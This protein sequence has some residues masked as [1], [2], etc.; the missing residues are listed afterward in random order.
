MN[1]ENIIFESYDQ[2]YIENVID[3]LQDVSKYRPLN[4]SDPSFS[5]SFLK[6]NNVYALVALYEKKVIGFGSIFIFERVRG[7]KSAILEDIVVKNSFR[8]RKV[9]TQIINILIKYAATNKCFKISLESSEF[10]KNFYRKLGF[11]DKGNIMNKFL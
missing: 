4:S 2:K 11:V 9:G 6:Q 5:N 7:G 1:S 8:Y 3:L 10:S